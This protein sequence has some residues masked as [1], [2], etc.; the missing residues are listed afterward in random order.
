MRPT[1]PGAAS[2]RLPAIPD[3]GQQ[4][5][6]FPLLPGEFRA[7]HIPRTYDI[8]PRGRM[9]AIVFHG[10]AVEVLYQEPKDIM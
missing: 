10:N 2:L 4:G 3:D 9:P 5:P 6:G 7:G 8:V 1:E